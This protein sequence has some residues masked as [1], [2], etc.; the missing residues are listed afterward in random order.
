[1]PSFFIRLGRSIMAAKEEETL[2]RTQF[3]KNALMRDECLR[4]R[5]ENIKY[6][7]SAIFGSRKEGGG[8]R[9]EAKYCLLNSKD[10]EFVRFRFSFSS[11]EKT[12]YMTFRVG[13]KTHLHEYID[14][15]RS[16]ASEY[17]D[18]EGTN[19]ENETLLVGDYEKWSE[20]RNRF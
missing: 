6:A 12:Y 1:M 5:D 4:M 8:T 20:N 18:Q 11:D 17:F 7:I 3:S 13:K 15:C 9:P 14:R 19:D 10:F 2:A 16:G